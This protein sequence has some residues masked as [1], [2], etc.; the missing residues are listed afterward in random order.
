[1]PE[2]DVGDGEGNG[3]ERGFAFVEEVEVVVFYVY[4]LEFNKKECGVLLEGK[5]G[6]V[7]LK[8]V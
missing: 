2:G 1:M 5:E 4:F 6:S 7:L 3:R 8:E